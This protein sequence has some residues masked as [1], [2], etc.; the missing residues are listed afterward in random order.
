M[1][2]TETT[3]DSGFQIYRV[4]RDSG[5]TW[6]DFPENPNRQSPEKM[7]DTYRRIDATQQVAVNKRLT[8]VW[9]VLDSDQWRQLYAMWNPLSQSIL[10][11]YTDLRYKLVSGVYVPRW[12]KAPAVWAEEPAYEVQG[13]VYL[14]VT[15]VFDKVEWAAVE[16]I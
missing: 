7:G 8:L 16:Q 4:S 11:N 5:S 6:T 2:I 13:P 9:N 3:T 14:N 15:V 10:L 1:A 12:Y